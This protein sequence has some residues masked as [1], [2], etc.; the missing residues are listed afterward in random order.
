M[1][2]QSR[3]FLRVTMLVATCSSMALWLV[4]SAQAGDW[5]Q[6]RG[7]H[8]DGKSP[9]TGLLQEWP[10][11]GPPLQLKASGLG[12]G[13]SS[14]SGASVRWSTWATVAISI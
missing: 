10:E 14:V 2:G 7:M 12:A 4:G 3:H 13:Y 11:G 8:R 6:W 1:S 5:P 9:D